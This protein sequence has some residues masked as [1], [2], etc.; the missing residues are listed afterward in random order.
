MATIIVTYLRQ[1]TNKYSTAS[2][3]DIQVSARDR[4]MAIAFVKTAFVS[5]ISFLSPAMV[6]LDNQ[7]RELA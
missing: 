6:N 3:G 4:G 1:N 2:A 5:K 7:N